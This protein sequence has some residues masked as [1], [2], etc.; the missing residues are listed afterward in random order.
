LA[1]IPESKRRTEA[2]VWLD[3]ETDSPRIMGAIL[4]AVAGGLRH[5]PTVQLLKLPRMADFAMWGEA[6]CRGWGNQPDVFLDAYTD[7]RKQ[8]NESVLE[9]SPVA[10]FV[11]NL[12]SAS[13]WAGTSRELLDV[14][15]GLAGEKAVQS[16][17]WPKKPTCSLG[18]LAAVGP[19]PTDGWHYG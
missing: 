5:L 13:K 10:H 2:A 17:R 1:P 4:D 15:A 16:K 6:V 14:L 18:N 9:D 12:A 19:V 8:A 11:K 7:N 3:V